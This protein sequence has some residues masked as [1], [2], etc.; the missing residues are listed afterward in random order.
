MS[1]MSTLSTFT[2]FLGL[3]LAAVILFLLRRDHLYLGHGLF[4]MT[5]AFAAAI[6][7]L[8]PKLIDWIAA[9][10][11]VAYPPA[12]L[13]LVVLVMLTTKALHADLL[14][15]RTER[16]LREL[17]QQLALLQIELNALSEGGK[18]DRSKDA[19]NG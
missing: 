16:Q 19:H 5:T 4:W 15:T 12:A 10:M 7:G 1:T 6:L 17:N 9:W 13:F 18:G 8:W 14:H 11:G 3:G 2:M